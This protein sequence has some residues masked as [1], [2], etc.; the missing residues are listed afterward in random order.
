MLL[1]FFIMLLIK[2]ISISENT[3][4]NY[5]PNAPNPKQMLLIQQEFLISSKT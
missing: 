4:K 5:K 3:P 2:R 1:N